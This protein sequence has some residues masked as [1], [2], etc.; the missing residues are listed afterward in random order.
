MLM[1][2][3]GPCSILTIP[4]DLVY[5]ILDHLDYLEILFSARNVCTRL[6]M[7]TDTYPRYAVIFDVFHRSRFLS[8]SR[9]HFIA[10]MIILFIDI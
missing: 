9:H 3:E 8:S 4:V 10:D 1:A 5:R 6:N 7:I 2:Y